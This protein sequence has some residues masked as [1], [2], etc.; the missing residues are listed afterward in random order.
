MRIGII[1]SG[2][3]ARTLG[4]KLAEVGHGVTI[5][6]RDTRQPKESP[7]GPIPSADDWAAQQ[8]ERGFEAA[9][10]GFAAAAAFGEFVINATAGA[11]SLAALGSAGAD[12]LR[13]KIL[14]DLANPLDFSHGMPPALLVCNTDS[15]GEQI[16]AAFPD[17]RVVKTLNTVAAP[18]MVDP[19][20]LPE[21]TT[22]FV[23]AND[24]KAKAWVTEHLLRRSL[25]W[26]R[27]VDLG[28]IS[29]AR[30]TEMYLPLWVRL[31]G[32]TGTGILNVRLVI[33]QD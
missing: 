8:R 33:E 11:G 4:G 31:F 14:V 1:G 19:E 30:G 3:V 5:S 15:L 18:L 32:V 17:T 29:S 23:A 27:V 16:Q 26:E 2:V 10:T 21:Q 7:T 20:R 24:G 9:A 22:V 25:G 28:D 12:N 13:G 6:S